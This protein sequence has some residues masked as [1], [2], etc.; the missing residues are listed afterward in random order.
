MVAIAWPSI[1]WYCVFGVF[2]YYQQ[3][4]GRDFK[5]ASHVFALALNLFAFAG[6]L[7]GFAYLGYYGWNVSWLGAIA[8]F[9]LGI[10]AM[11]PGVLVERIVGKLTLSFT[12]FVV[13]PLA[14]YMM[15]R[16]I[17]G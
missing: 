14:A 15:F 8:A 17:P 7:V 10:V 13:W 2:V 3:L 12:G 9:I 6:M 16:Y 1:G 4:H 5:G 11:I